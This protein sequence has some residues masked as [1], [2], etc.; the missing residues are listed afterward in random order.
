LQKYHLISLLLLIFPTA[1]FA[2]IDPYSLSLEELMNIP[3]TVSSR[4]PLSQRKTPGIVSVITAEEIRQSGARDLV[5]VLRQVPG[6]DFRVTV[7]NGIA[8][9]MRGHIGSDGRVL[10]L[11]D[12]IEVNDLRYG[13]AN[14]AQG[15]PV[16][17]IARIEIIRGSGLA[18]YG[19]TALLGVINI[20]SKSTEELAGV[21]VGAGLGYAASGARSRDYISLM[22]GLRGDTAKLSVMAHKGQALRSDRTYQDVSGNSFNMATA[23]AIYPEFLNVGLQ[24]GNFSARYLR[25]ASQVNDRDGSA[26]NIRVADYKNYYLSD[27]LLVQQL[28]QATPELTLT[29]SVT[30]LQQNPRKTVKPDGTVTSETSVNRLQTKLPLAWAVSSAWHISGGLEYVSE[31]YQGSVRLYPLKPLPFDSTTIAS[32]YGEILSRNDWGDITVSARLDDH[33]HSGLLQAERLGYTKIF[34]DWHVKL[35]GSVAERAPSMEGYATQ[36]ITPLKPETARTWEME[37]G[38]RLSADSQFTVNIFDITTDD[39]LVLVNMQ[40]VHTRGLEAGY[41][42]RKDWGYGEVNYSYYNA[43]GTDTTLIKVMR[44]PFE[45]P[46]VDDTMNLAF[47]AHKLTANLHYKLADDW[48]VNSTL[49]YLGSRWGKVAPNI[50]GDG[51][52]LK[53]FAPTPLLNIV[54]SWDNALLKD[55]DI[56][57]GLYNALNQEVDFISPMNS[58]HAPL[59]DM[60]REVLLQTQYKF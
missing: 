5:D 59:P 38:Y 43:A 42:I 3:V 54:L 51:G 48:S 39:T 21:Q 20:I 36:R 27:S 7:N 55:L 47:P 32:F 24:I 25:D 58:Y 13:G 6:M 4:L 60:S 35:M 8:P 28:F 26:S 46:V 29:P 18:L 44:D 37:T 34:G 14:F 11:V 1:A 45:S 15:F 16:E 53:S 22:G 10:M 12:G 30:Y 33:S 50:N 41:K 23:N 17:Q 31:N 40:T 9:G 52:Q 57:L 49:V 56:T 19:G 2:E